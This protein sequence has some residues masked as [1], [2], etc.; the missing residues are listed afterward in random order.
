MADLA[1]ILARLV[2]AD[3]PFVLIGGYAAAAH[4]S[5]MVTQD[6]DVC[7]PFTPEAIARLQ[8]AIAPLHPVD[9]QH[10][11]RL[12]VALDPDRL[13]GIHNLYLDTDL[14]P[15]DLLGEVKGI[16]DYEAARAASMEVQVGSR[17][18]H[19]LS[20]EAL[21]TSKEAMGRP[22]DREVVRELNALEEQER[23]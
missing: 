7:C 9:R 22:R 2:D 1:G 3:F 12:A 6:V 20:R 10:P 17:R 15:L 13:R 11:E 23:K 16:G 14:G 21:I 5:T 4:G 19:I 18:L 8:T